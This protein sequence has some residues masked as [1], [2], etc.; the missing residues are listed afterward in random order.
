MNK[1]LSDIAKMIGGYVKG[2]AAI[3]I[4]GLS[5][6]RE[7]ESGDLTFLANA[8]Y[9]PLLEK[10]QASA[11]IVA[12]GV[13]TGKL[14]AIIVENPSLAFSKLAED[15]F[16]ASAPTIKGI[17]K[18]AVIGKDVHLGQN[19]AVGPYAVIEDGVVLGD[20]TIICALTFIGHGT[21]IGKDGLIYP[22]VT[23]R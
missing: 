11:V 21:K 10:T 9:L 7:A 16:K 5:G 20:N 8:K 4:T 14:A 3:M 19:V 12:Q 17:N 18:T 2:D 13:E 1:T 22:H 6:I 23:I 15:F